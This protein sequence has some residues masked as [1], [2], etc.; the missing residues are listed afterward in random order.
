MKFRDVAIA[1][2]LREEKLT[3]I[4]QVNRGLACNCLCP[5]C[6]V[7]LIARKGPKKADHFAHIPGQQCDNP[8]ESVLHL[9]AKQ[10]ICESD[11]I[12]IPPYRFVRERK[13]RNGNVVRINKKLAAG[14]KTKISK[15]ETEVSRKKIRSDIEILSR[16][17]RL[18][19]EIAVTSRA[20]KNKKARVKRNNLP[21]IEIRLEQYDAMLSREQL[22]QKVLDNT[23]NKTCLFHPNEIAAR[24]EFSELY[25]SQEKIKLTPRSDYNAKLKWAH[26]AGLVDEY[27]KKKSR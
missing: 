22:A 13:M 23:D 14:G 15:V 25:Q 16:G 27:F 5:K 26:E 7:R 3:H 8:A 4:S 19:I 21:A 24:K 9:M 11:Y 6:H 12:V 17:K 2:G 1:Y 10:I 18:I 20:T